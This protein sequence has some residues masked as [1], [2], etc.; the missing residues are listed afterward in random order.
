MPRIN[1]IPCVHAVSLCVH[2]AQRI[3][4]KPPPRAARP[5]EDSLNSTYLWFMRAN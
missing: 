1:L 3:T 2:A 5:E 4:E